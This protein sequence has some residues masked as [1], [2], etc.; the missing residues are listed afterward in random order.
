MRRHA[1][2]ALLSLGVAAAPAIALAG[3]GRSST[4]SSA[5]ANSSSSTS[6][7][8]GRGLTVTPASGS[9]A[10][11]F[12]FGFIAPASSV[13]AHGSEIGFTLALTGPDH[14]GC[15]GSRSLA[16]PAATKGDPVSVKVDPARLGGSW[17]A[18]VHAARAIEIQAP[19]CSPTVMCPQYIRVV[20]VVGTTTFR[21]GT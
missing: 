14:N 6:T 10:T 9:P 16:V 20:G 1:L 4:A 13:R 11:T 18:G 21:V 7:G 2:A 17:C 3:C 8:A 15:I 5:A 12:S 19:L